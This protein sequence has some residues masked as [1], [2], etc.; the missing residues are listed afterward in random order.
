MLVAKQ[1]Q[2]AFS[3]TRQVP[4][5]DPRLVGVGVAAKLVDRAEHLGGVILVHEGA[6]AVI[7][8]LARYRGVV[9]VHDAVD[10]ADQEPARDQVGLA[11]DHAVQ[12]GMVGTVG[13]CQIGV[14]PAD[15]MIRQPPYAL[16]I[17]TH[18]KILERS[19]TNVAGCDAGE[20]GARQRCLAQYALAG[21]DRGE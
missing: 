1:R 4:E 12:K 10:E 18:R 21:H 8:G 9:G 14:V 7:D 19:D 5:R 17:A 11:R 2:Q 16:R 13:M 6:R 15:H 20:D 3:E